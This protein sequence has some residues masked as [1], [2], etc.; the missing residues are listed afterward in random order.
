ML[1]SLPKSAPTDS[2]REIQVL[3]KEAEIG[4]FLPCL[5]V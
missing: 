5:S 4:L 2:A 3:R 1:Q